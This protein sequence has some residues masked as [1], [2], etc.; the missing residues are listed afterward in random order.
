MPTLV[1]R[2]RRTER[3]RPAPEGRSPYARTGVEGN[4]RSAGPRAVGRACSG[5]LFFDA[6]AGNRPIVLGRWPGFTEGSR[7]QRGSGGGSGRALRPRGGPLTRELGWRGMGGLLAHV[8]WEGLAVACS[9]STRVQGTAPSSWVA[10]RQAQRRV[11]GSAAHRSVGLRLQL[12]ARRC[13][14]AAMLVLVLVLLLM[15]TLFVFLRDKASSWSTCCAEGWAAR[16]LRVKG[17]RPAPEG[18][19]PYARTGVEGNGRSAGPRAVGSACS[20]VLFFDARAGN[21]PIVLG[22][23]PGFTESEKAA[24]Q[25]RV[26]GTRPAPEGRSPYA[27]TGVAGNGRSAGPRAVG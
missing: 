24:R 26:K 16:Q 2:S 5:V 3:T 1:L 20:G 7:R 6:R 15:P 27:R 13:S 19:S 12:L 21:R 17:T 11:A 4:E 25:L 14:R 9:F 23:W 10:G 22:R 18:R 8:R